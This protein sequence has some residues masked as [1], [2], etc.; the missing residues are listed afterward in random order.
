[1]SAPTATP[2]AKSWSQRILRSWPATV[3]LDRIARRTDLWLAETDAEREALLRLRYRIYAEEQGDGGGIL[4][5]KDGCFV[6]PGDDEPGVILIGF[7]PR[8]APLGTVRVQ[9][10]A[11]GCVP[12]DYARDHELHRF[13]GIER[14]RV[15]QVGYLMLDRSIRGSLKGLGYVLGAMDFA[16]RTLRP[17]LLFAHAAPGLVGPYKRLG[18]RTYGARPFGS[19]RGLEVPLAIVPHLQWLRTSA[20]LWAPVLLELYRDGVIAAASDSMLAPFAA[21]VV[22]TDRRRVSDAWQAVPTHDLSALSP[23]VAEWVQSR[24][25]VYEVGPGVTLTVQDF[26]GADVMLLTSGSVQL[27]QDGTILDRRWAGAVLGEEAWHSSRSRRACTIRT[28]STVTFLNFRGGDL[29]RLARE[30]PGA[31]DELTECFSRVEH[32]RVRVPESR[33]SQQVA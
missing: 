13:D 3:A 18:F 8:L 28:T 29:R 24:A 20:C 14:S 2:P 23:T 30:L 6:A 1:M 15:A 12:E 5:L 17:D 27:E 26:F 11:P 32:A 31:A 25:S 16:A 4:D 33:P 21:S 19:S 7:G 10:W 9:T 22:H